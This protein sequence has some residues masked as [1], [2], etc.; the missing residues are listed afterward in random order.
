MKAGHC[1]VW[2]NLL[3]IAGVALMARTSV[4]QEPPVPA[5]SAPT[6]A[7]TT[8]GTEPA[9]AP[10][11]EP[12]I[13]TVRPQKA[14]PAPALL[15][16]VTRVSPEGAAGPAEG[17]VLTVSRAERRPPPEGITQMGTWVGT[18]GPDGTVGVDVPPVAKDTQFDTHTVRYMDVPYS[19]KPTG[20]QASVMVFE[21]TRDRASLG[22]NALHVVSVQEGSLVINAQF[23]VSNRSLSVVDADGATGLRLPLLLPSALGVT[24]DEGGLP[25]SPDTQKVRFDH[26]P[27][28]GRL[29]FDRGALTYRGPIL[30][31]DNLQVTALYTVSYDAEQHYTLGF[32]SDIDLEGLQVRVRTSDRTAPRAAPRWPYRAAAQTDVDDRYFYFVF[33]APPKAGD[34]FLL[35]LENTPG[36]TGM[37]RAVAVGGVLFLAALFVLGL[38]A[39]LRRR[40]A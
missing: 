23:V 37:N 39:G 19:V 20:N 10:T 35:D 12:P 15:V 17:A 9:V 33:D 13:V 30:P 24:L 38:F 11:E 18:S 16:R 5:E 2:R 27:A 21:P 3:V 32:T 40:R 25:P 22:L 7:A 4:A 34:A 29:T 14:K 1:N 36:R 28:M 31:G 6:P 8:D 26:Q